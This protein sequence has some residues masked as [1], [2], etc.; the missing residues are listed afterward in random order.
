MLTSMR[1]VEVPAEECLSEMIGS[2]TDGGSGR[3][4]G[5]WPVRDGENRTWPETPTDIQRLLASSQ[6]TET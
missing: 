5:L 1:L 6:A 3:P 4:E 2:E